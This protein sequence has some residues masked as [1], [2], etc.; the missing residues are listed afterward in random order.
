M[1]KKTTTKNK[2]A[3]PKTQ[4]KAP[5]GKLSLIKAA[6]AILEQSEQAMNTRQLVEAAKE[7]G[8]WEPTGGKT[9]EQTLYSAIVREI[10][11]KGDCARFAT[12]GKGLFV[13]ATH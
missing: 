13:L 5:D 4:P 10:K 3:E 9:P 11:A 1:A 7:Q 6:I 2:P 12:A 8:L